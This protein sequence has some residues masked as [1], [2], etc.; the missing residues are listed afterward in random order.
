MSGSFR[1]P[2]EPVPLSSS[3]PVNYTESDWDDPSS[4]PSSPSFEKRTSQTSVD[5]FAG[6]SKNLT[7]IPRYNLGRAVTEPARHTKDADIAGLTLV[8]GSDAHNA[9]DQQVL[10]QFFESEGEE[11]VQPSSDDN[12]SSSIESVSY[13][14]QTRLFSRTESAGTDPLSGVGTSRTAE[15]PAQRMRMVGTS[16]KKLTRRSKPEFDLPHWE[17]MQS[18]TSSEPSQ[19][20]ASRIQTSNEVH[21]PALINRIFDEG[22]ETPALVLGGCHL[23]TI[24]S[25]IGDLHSYVAIAP[26]RLEFGRRSESTHD[27]RR[28]QLQCYLWDN[29]LTRLPSALFQLQNLTV[30]SLR[31]NALRSLPSAIGEL[32]N[33]REL[34]VGGNQLTCLPAEIQRLH[35]DTFTYIPNPFRSIPKD[36]LLSLRQRNSQQ[37]S[38]HPPPAPRVLQRARTEMQ[39]RP[40]SIPEDPT[41]PVA[42]A[43]GPL[44]RH[45][46]P[47]LTELCIRLLLS[48]DGDTMLLD[49]YE[50]GSLRS[51]QHTLDIQL[52][53]HLESARR[54]S[55]RIWGSPTD[56]PHTARR[57]RREKHTW[58]EHAEF[59][60]ASTSD[61]D[62]FSETSAPL[63]SMDVD[64]VLEENE[65]AANNPY[66]NRCPNPHESA[67]AT[68][69][70]SDWPVAWSAMGQAPLFASA[71]EERME[72]V[73]YVAGVRVAKQG[74]ELMISASDAHTQMQQ[75]GCLPLLWRGCSAGCLWFLNA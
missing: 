36:A 61:S 39:I 35:L 19:A 32:H 25:M 49:K 4:P 44:Q 51:M 50:T 71:Y 6:S 7:R 63:N 34:N 13:L 3:P 17:Q 11:D 43:L 74:V 53:A 75:S 68:D 65:D 16:P 48:Q 56:L 31:K 64:H 72:W 10:A 30:L 21:W 60:P 33:L 54:S 28:N 22:R 18:S 8:P 70:V 69:G 46:L 26:P 15:Q 45:A 41:A 58:Y 62:V 42:R 40:G 52:I 12:L 23:E 59:H 9:D 37:P 24:P 2:T 47:T 38:M 67:P 14:P 73:P 66:F 55:S 29:Q 57:I 5:P 27:T 1:V 20:H